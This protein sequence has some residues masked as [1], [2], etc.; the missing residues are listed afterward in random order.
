MPSVMRGAD[1]AE[2][3]WQNP[4]HR[5]AGYQHLDFAGLKANGR[6]NGRSGAGEIAA[7]EE[8]GAGNEAGRR[9]SRRSAVAVAD[10]HPPRNVPV[11]QNGPTEGLRRAAVGDHGDPAVAQDT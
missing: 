6:G 10:A 7:F 5:L 11:Q 4:A 2:Q 1:S 3:K 9:G 8:S